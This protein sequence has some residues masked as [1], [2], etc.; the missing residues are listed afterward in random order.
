MSLGTGRNLS[1]R[2]YSGARRSFRVA[3]HVAAVTTLAAVASVPVA[4]GVCCVC[5]GGNGDLCS[6]EFIFDNCMQCETVCP[7][8]TGPGGTGRVRMCCDNV[9]DCSSNV[10][11]ST[12]CTFASPNPQPQLCVQTAIGF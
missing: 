12:S 7:L 5:E 6:Q 9:P 4:Q 3:P 10:A 8:F 11:D 1:R 2:S